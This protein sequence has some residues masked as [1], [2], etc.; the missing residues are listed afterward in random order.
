MGGGL[1]EVIGDADVP[2]IAPQNVRA[3]KRKTV[4]AK[5]CIQTSS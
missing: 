2:C 3:N 1:F 4:F 5:N